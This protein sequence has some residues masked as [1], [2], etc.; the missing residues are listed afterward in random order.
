VSDLLEDLDVEQPETAAIRCKASAKGLW[1]TDLILPEFWENYQKN[2]ETK[3]EQQLVTR[4]AYR[5]ALQKAVREARHRERRRILN[6]V[7]KAIENLEKAS[8]SAPESVWYIKE[9]V[10]DSKEIFEELEE[11]VAKNE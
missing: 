4:E 1:A 8:E 2:M 6:K 9:K 7:G 5:E 3:E 10:D 11:E